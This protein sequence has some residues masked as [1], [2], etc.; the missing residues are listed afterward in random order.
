MDPLRV[1]DVADDLAGLGID[2][3]HVRAAGDEEAVR[4]GIDFEVIP[5]SG[6]AELDFFGKVVTGSARGLRAGQR[7]EKDK[8][9]SE[10]ETSESEFLEHRSS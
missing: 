6:T 4:G 8:E 10:E 2:D 7:S 3:D 1:R 9:R 5:A